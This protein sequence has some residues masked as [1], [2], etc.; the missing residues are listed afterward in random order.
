MLNPENIGAINNLHYINV[1]LILQPT[2]FFKL[3]KSGLISHVNYSLNFYENCNICDL[4]VLT[5]SVTNF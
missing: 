3:K 4:L 2:E 5:I 1:Q